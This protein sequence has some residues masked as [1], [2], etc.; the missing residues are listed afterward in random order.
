MDWKAAIMS[1][2]T[3]WNRYAAIWSSDPDTRSSELAACLADDVNY[4][5]PNGLVAGRPA[6][7][8]YMGGFQLSAPGAKFCIDK[9][10]HHHDRT[11]AHWT[12]YGPGDNALQT[13]TSFGQLDDDGRLRSITGFFYQ[14]GR[15]QLP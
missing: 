10:I 13:G 9:V 6:I 12:L 7:S 3:L 4:C 8:A 2:E 15:S 1:P 14:S 5:D 11:L